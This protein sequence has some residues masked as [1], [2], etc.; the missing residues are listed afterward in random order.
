[1]LINPILWLATISYC[2]L[3]GLVGPAIESV[4]P[5]P[6][7]YMAGFSLVFGNFLYLYNYMIGCAKREHWS[8]VKFIFLVP[9]YWLAVSFAAVIAVFQLIFKP[10]YWEKTHHGLDLKY[11]LQ[12]AGITRYP[13]VAPSPTGIRQPSIAFAGAVLVGASIL[14]N[15]SGFLYNAYLGRRLLLEEFGVVSLL[16]SFFYIAQI[17]F[18]SLS[19]TVTYRSAYILGK[20]KTPAKLFWAFASRRSVKLAFIV[21]GVWMLSIPFWERFFNMESILPCFCLPQSGLPAQLL[22]LIVDFY[23]ER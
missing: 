10:Y 12:E 22:Q 9:F 6:V 1:M 3:Y 2:V 23:Q 14:G 4:Y 5:T 17:L 7:F 15:L 13:K 20:Y 8:L 19:K 21:S 16:G 11:I 18:G